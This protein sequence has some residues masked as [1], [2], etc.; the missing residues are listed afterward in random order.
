[1]KHSAERC[2][3]CA[4]TN[5]NL[6][7]EHSQLEITPVCLARTHELQ[8]QRHRGQRYLRSMRLAHT[9]ELQPKANREHICQR[10]VRLARTNELQHDVLCGPVAVSD[11]APHAHRR[12]TTCP[13]KRSPYNTPWC[14]SRAPTNYNVTGEPGSASGNRVR[15]VRTHELQLQLH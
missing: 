12:I 8:L 6:N 14:A 5:Y 7:F 2:A 11:G 4:P 9:N 1:M 13:P 10:P 15:L 3:S